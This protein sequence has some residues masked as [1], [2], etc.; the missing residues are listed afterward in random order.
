[1]KDF[2]TGNKIKILLHLLA[3]TIILGIPIYF[4][5]RWDVGKDFIWLYYIGN[6]INGIIFYTNYLILVPKFFFGSQKHK[7]YLSVIFLLTFLYFI[8]YLSNELIFKYVP[9]RNNTEEVNISKKEG[10]VPPPKP[11]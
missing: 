7:Y 1:M 9:G 6:I 11:D 4:F 8:S 3:W 10:K 5:K 2:F